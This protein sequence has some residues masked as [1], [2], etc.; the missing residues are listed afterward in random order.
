[1]VSSSSLRFGSGRHQHTI[2]QS[3]CPAVPL[4]RL[5]GTA[6]A[7]PLAEI[8]LTPRQLNTSGKRPGQPRRISGG[9]RQNLPGFTMLS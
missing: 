2:S 4:P 3:R 9:V 5:P 6:L 8:V 7:P 1:M